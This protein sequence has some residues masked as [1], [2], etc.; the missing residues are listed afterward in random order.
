MVICLT[1]H[2][3]SSM[4]TIMDLMC[5]VI[6]VSILRLGLLPCLLLLTTMTVVVLERAHRIS[7]IGYDYAIKGIVCQR[8]SGQESL[9][10]TSH[11]S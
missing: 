10:T 4:E 3:G 7:T 5:T 11:P 6:D 1:L 9:Q 8:G 2:H